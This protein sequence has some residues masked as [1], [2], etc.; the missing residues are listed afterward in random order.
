M[1][2]IYKVRR[3]NSRIKFKLRELNLKLVRLFLFNKLLTQFGVFYGTFLEHI[4]SILTNLRKCF[5]KFCF[6]TNNSV[7]ARFLTRYMALKLKRKFPL[8]YVINP[9]KKELRK[10][11]YK[12][13]KK[14]KNLIFSFLNY[15]TD[16]KKIEIDYKF[17]FRSV[18]NLLLLRYNKTSKFYYKKYK[19]YITYEFF[20]F[21]FLLKENRKKEK[22]QLLL[23]F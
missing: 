4:V 8:F 20:P 23:N 19:T 2:I 13:R 17:I 11:A 22:N 6:I 15:K 21:F 9:L 10:L 1:N 14:K 3:T 16:L 12:K 7:N 18:L 5:F